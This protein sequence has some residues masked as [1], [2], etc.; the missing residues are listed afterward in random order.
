MAG[1]GGFGQDGFDEGNAV[2]Y[3]WIVPRNPA[4]LITAMGGREAA[5]ARLDAF[6]AKLN[7]G[8][9]QPYM[10]AGNEPAFGIPWLYNHTGRPWRTQQ[11][12][13]QIMT[14]LF[15][16]TPDG[17]SGNDD[18]GAQSSWYV[19]AALG[20]YPGTPGT[21]DLAVHSPLFPRAVLDLPGRDQAHRPIATVSTTSW[22]VPTA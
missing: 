7:A 5:A 2:Q 13:R 18:L 19:W 6:S 1:T 10:W 4:G 22:P 11:V 16:A 8:P 12:V 14:T 21:S 17:E 15:N 9:L 20:L 3:T